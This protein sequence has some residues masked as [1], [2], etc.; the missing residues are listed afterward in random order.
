MR[1][2]ALAAAP[3][4]AVIGTS[5]GQ[6]HFVV[7]STGKEDRRSLYLEGEVLAIALTHDVRDDPK[8]PKMVAATKVG[9]VAGF[10]YKPLK[11]WEVPIHESIPSPPTFLTTTTAGCVVGSST[12][13]LIF[14]G[15]DGSLLWQS[16]MGTLAERHE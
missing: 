5:N 2:T 7:T 6:L 9:T 13:D 14:I 10:N 15:M 1:V 3:G 8:V 12:G 16:T 4:H 11:L